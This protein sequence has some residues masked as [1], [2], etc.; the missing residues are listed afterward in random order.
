MENEGHRELLLDEARVENQKEGRF[1]AALPHAADVV[2]L[3]L[4]FSTSS[5]LLLGHGHL[6]L[7]VGDLLLGPATVLLQVKHGQMV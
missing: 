6:L 4:L 5:Q 1:V 3:L 2:L 7:H